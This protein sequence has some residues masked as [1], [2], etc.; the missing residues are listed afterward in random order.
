MSKGPCYER[1]MAKSVAACGVLLIGVGAVAT[2]HAFTLNTLFR[3]TGVPVC[4][5]S[6]NEFS[7]RTFGV[8]LV[9][10]ILRALNVEIEQFRVTIFV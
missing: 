5:F 10:R 7:H 9:R 1:A 4:R 3:C 8:R 6:W 2:E